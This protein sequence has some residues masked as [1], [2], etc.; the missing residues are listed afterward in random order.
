MFDTVS[1]IFPYINFTEIKNFWETNICRDMYQFQFFFFLEIISSYH[2]INFSGRNL[3][4]III[5]FYL[6]FLYIFYELWIRGIFNYLISR[7]YF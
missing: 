1:I 3:I 2:E 6:N 5:I 4:T 7:N